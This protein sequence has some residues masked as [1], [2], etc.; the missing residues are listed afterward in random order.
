MCEKCAR[1]GS[2]AI[3]VCE[4]YVMG[5]PDGI[6]ACRKCVM[7]SIGHGMGVRELCDGV[8]RVRQGMHDFCAG[9]IGWDGPRHKCADGVRRMK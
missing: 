5:L 7:G 8:H 6:C 3:L 4:K 2:D 1:G 9:C